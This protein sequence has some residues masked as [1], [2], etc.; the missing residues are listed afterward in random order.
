M[1]TTTTTAAT[2]PTREQALR[3]LGRIHGW[4]DEDKRA[5]ASDE[6]PW[7][8]GS[9]VGDP[10]EAWSLTSEEVWGAIPQYSPPITVNAII[11][12]RPGKSLTYMLR[13]ASP[14]PVYREHVWSLTENRLTHTVAT[15][16]TPTA[17][18]HAASYYRH[19]VHRDDG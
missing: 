1:T 9:D 16:S 19:P 8:D 17:P 14:Q 15:Q 2:D 10:T 3:I 13:F 11:E 18:D 7:H 6:H 12:L 5:I 4:W